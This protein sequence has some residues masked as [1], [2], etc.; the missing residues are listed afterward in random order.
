M[1]LGGRFRE[2]HD[3]DVFGRQMEQH[4]DEFMQLQR[5]RICH[6]DFDCHC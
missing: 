4:T 3:F 1:K 5:P 2:P 6:G